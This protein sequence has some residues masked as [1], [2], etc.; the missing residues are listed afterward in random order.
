MR[1]PKYTEEEIKRIEKE[2]DTDEE[3]VK[4]DEEL[5][6]DRVVKSVFIPGGY[7][8]HLAREFNNALKELQLPVLKGVNIEFNDKEVVDAL[9]S[10]GDRIAYFGFSRTLVGCQACYCY[11]KLLDEG[12]SEKDAHFITLLK[13]ISDTLTRL[14]W[15]S[16][17]NFDCTQC[18]ISDNLTLFLAV[19]H[20]MASNSPDTVCIDPLPEWRPEFEEGLKKLNEILEKD[21]KRTIFERVYT[22]CFVCLF[23][24]T[25]TKYFKDK[26]GEDIITLLLSVVRHACAYGIAS[27]CKR[28]QIINVR[29][30]EVPSPIQ[31]KALDEYRFKVHVEILITPNFFESVRLPVVAETM[32]LI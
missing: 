8:F 6:K 16:D 7:E 4:A 32:Q 23:I 17:N 10:L 20:N 19:E 27:K 18:T 21:E 1:L 30:E 12:Y 11:S 26:K 14:A 24:K 15:F 29:V 22:K 31:K 13:L 9:K 3:W 28:C 5:G 2:F 25:V